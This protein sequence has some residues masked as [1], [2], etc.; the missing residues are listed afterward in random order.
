MRWL[1]LT[2]ALYLSAA[3]AWADDGY[4]LKLQ[5]AA[6][7]KYEALTTPRAIRF[8]SQA[9]KYTIICRAPDW[10]VH[11]FRDE[12]REI[13]HCS[14]AE[15]ERIRRGAIGSGVTLDFSHKPKVTPISFKA[16]GKF[17]KDFTY[18]GGNSKARD[19]FVSGERPSDVDKITVRTIDL[20]LPTEINTIIASVVCM[21]QLPGTIYE[22]IE[23]QKPA[24]AFW[25]VH[26]DSV[27]SMHDLKD[28]VF[29]IPQHYKDLGKFEGTFLFKS[30][31][32]MMDEVFDSLG[33]SKI[34]E[35]KKH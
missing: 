32:G 15:F 8:T 3:A 35:R 27:K 13:C 18:P 17:G 24:T 14:V 26:T 28:S 29:A 5:T 19:I 20:K 4:L 22:T 33:S 10:K 31:S 30:V 12:T 1:F 23:F 11:I 16:I 6:G 7:G 2:I 25:V 9:F 21:P 34:D